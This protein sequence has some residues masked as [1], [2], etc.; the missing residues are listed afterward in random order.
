MGRTVTWVAAAAG[1]LLGFGLV[2]VVSGWTTPPTSRRRLR[3]PRSVDVLLPARLAVTAVAA[4]LIGL[5]TRWPVGAVAAGA[6]AWYLFGLAAAGQRATQRQL[7]KVEAI[8]SWVEMLRDGLRAGQGL[9]DVLRVTAPLAPVAI[10]P[11]VRRLVERLERQRLAV[12]LV[13]FG[14]D[15][16]DPLGDLVVTALLFCSRRSSPDLS[17]VL[18]SL[19]GQARAEASMRLRVDARRAENRTEVRTVVVASVLFLVALTFTSQRLLHPYGTVRGQLVLAG[20]VTVFAVALVWL[21]RL[22][23]IRVGSRVLQPSAE[24]TELS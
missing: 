4:T 15:L 5:W 19:A 12:A 7:A 18:G 11:E 20:I 14:E 2:L 13:A 6:G 16:A 24:M 21:G 22:A 1:A 8:A 10:R 9:T 23:R 17:A 3:V